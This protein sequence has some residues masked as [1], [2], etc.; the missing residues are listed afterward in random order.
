MD[1]NN[2]KSD[3]FLFQFGIMNRFSFLIL[4]TNQTAKP[5]QIVEFCS[6]LCDRGQLLASALIPKDKINMN[7]VGHGQQKAILT[8]FKVA[9]QD[10]YL[11]YLSYR[12]VIACI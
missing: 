11:G 1:L 7:V 6:E 12:I 8:S 3:V 5:L 4:T 10:C 2:L 9:L